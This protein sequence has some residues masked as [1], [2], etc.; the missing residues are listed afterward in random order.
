MTDRQTGR[1]IQIKAIWFTYEALEYHHITGVRASLIWLQ[2]LL[3]VLWDK[4]G[5]D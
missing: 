5:Q 3:S 4:K 2:N 1:Q